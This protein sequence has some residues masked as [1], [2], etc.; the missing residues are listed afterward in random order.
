[1]YIA[2]IYTIAAVLATQLPQSNAALQN[3]SNLRKEL[4][5]PQVSELAKMKKIV[6][7]QKLEIDSLTNMVRQME[8]KLDD[9]HLRISEQQR[10]LKIGITPFLAD[11]TQ[12]PTNPLGPCRPLE[13]EI[14]R[15]DVPKFPPEGQCIL[16]D[17]NDC[18]R[19][20]CG[21]ATC[22]LCPSEEPSSQ[23]SSQPSSIV[24]CIFCC[25][26]DFHISSIL[27]SLSLLL[28][29]A[30]VKSIGRTLVNSFFPTI[31]SAVITT[32]RRITI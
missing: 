9:A 17:P 29:L 13:E 7:S 32:I 2:I 6:K 19:C 28:V 5:P 8:G 30:L 31:Q 10:Q 18:A 22:N 3:A 16:E 24:S 14:A 27:T 20:S 23:P 11:Q 1:M 4:G 12:E 15:D 25:F 21:C 26:L